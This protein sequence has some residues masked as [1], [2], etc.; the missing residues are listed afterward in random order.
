MIDRVLVPIDGSELSK[1]A[2]KYALEVH[3]DAEITVL[4]VAGEPSPM[5][6]E[7]VRLA[8]ETD[9]ESA[10]E[11][12][13]ADV[14]EEAH[15]IASEYGAELDTTVALGSPARQIINLAS[16]YDAV[17]MGSH[18]GD[19]RSTLVTGNVARKVSNRASVPVTLVR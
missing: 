15:E 2:L 3:P 6:G 7:A 10:A 9:I 8:L 4:F 1:R 19:L 13:A 18:G 11:E 5:M 12:L 14:F 16:G 17:V